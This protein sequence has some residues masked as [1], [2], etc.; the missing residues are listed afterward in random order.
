[1]SVLYLL[2]GANHFI[3]PQMYAAIIPFWLPYP[4][5]LIHISGISEMVLA[6]LLLYPNYRKTAAWLIIAM[7]M[8]FLAVHI[9]MIFDKPTKFNIPMYVLVIRVALQFVLVWW[10]YLFTRNEKNKS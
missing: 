9:Q 5:E 4:N 3:N 2:A 7:L 10:A 8:V 6:I 1:M